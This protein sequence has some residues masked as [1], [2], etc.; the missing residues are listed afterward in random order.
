MTLVQVAG[1]FDDEALV[2][3]E[4]LA[5]LPEEAERGL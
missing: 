5:C 2:E 3:I 4:G 1:L